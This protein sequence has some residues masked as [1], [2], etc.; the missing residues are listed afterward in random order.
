MQVGPQTCNRNHAE[1][2]SVAQPLVEK[3][4]LLA[5]EPP[6]LE[7]GEVQEAEID[8]LLDFVG[9]GAGEKHERDVR[10][11]DLDALD[12]ERIRVRATEFAEK[13]SAVNAQF[14]LVHRSPFLHALE[15][16]VADRASRGK[17]ARF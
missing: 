2:D 7:R 13:P 11:L 10:F 6:P 12:G 16:T 8:W 17:E 14:V 3:D 5:K 15:A 9:I 4:F 1:V